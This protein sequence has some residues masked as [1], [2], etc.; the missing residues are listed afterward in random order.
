MD[1]LVK[2]EQ[3]GFFRGNN[4]GCAFAAFAAKDP[5][6]YGWRSLVTPVSPDA[7]GVQLRNAI[8]SPKTQALSLI[9]P[10]VQNANW[11]AP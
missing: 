4:A 8:D 10:S 6:K 3:R 11:A 2:E 5:V 7:I 9:F 1:E